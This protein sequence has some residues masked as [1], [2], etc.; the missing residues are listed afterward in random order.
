MRNAIASMLV[1]LL[2]VLGGRPQ[3]G[4]PL[5]NGGAILGWAIAA[6]LLTGS[7]GL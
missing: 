6:F 2:L 5:L 7:L 1:A 4:L 3:A